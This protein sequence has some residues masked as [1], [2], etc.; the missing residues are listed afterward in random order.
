MHSCSCTAVAL[1]P[2]PHK[3]SARGI[4]VMSE[5]AAPGDRLPVTALLTGLADPLEL[6][7]VA[8]AAIWC[9][10]TFA[11]RMNTRPLCVLEC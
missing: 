11:E 8:P 4:P 9:A 3:A 2:K 5:L 7:A 10:V 6:S 1:G